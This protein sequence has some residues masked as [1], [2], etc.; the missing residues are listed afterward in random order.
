MFL[1]ELFI[2][3]SAHGGDIEE[4]VERLA[5][6]FGGATAHI[7]TPADGLWRGESLEK[8]A[9]GIIEI[10]TPELDRAWW[11]ELRTNLE[12]RFEQ[13]EILIRATPCE[14]I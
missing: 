3:L 2:P 7:R 11:R 1:V 12:E 5:L 14:K 6:R 8:E 13:D 10:M 9:I 4:L